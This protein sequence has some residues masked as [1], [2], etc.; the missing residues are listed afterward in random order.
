MK[1]KSPQSKLAQKK[2]ESR[3]ILP[4]VDRTWDDF[5]NNDYFMTMPKHK[6]WRDKLIQDMVDYQNDPNSLTIV[7]FCRKYK[8]P[9]TK[10][11]EVAEQFSDVKFAF[12]QMKMFLAENRLDGRFKGKLTDSIF[13]G[14]FRLDDE[15][16]ENAEVEAKVKAMAK[17][18]DSNPVYNI[19]YQDLK[20]EGEPHV[21]K[22]N[23]SDS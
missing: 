7:G 1:K 16:R 5:Y 20:T 19:Y 15:S 11:Y 4:V 8:I 12:T 18:Q 2:T 17:N 21:E 3:T 9:R 6:P 23:K 22:D 14:L 10:L 13:H